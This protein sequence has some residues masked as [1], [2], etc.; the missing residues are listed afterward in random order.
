MNIYIY[1]YIFPETGSQALPACFTKECKVT[2]LVE[3]R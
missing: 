2:A 1:I 3:A